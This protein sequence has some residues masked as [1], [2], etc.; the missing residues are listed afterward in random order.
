LCSEVPEPILALSRAIADN[1]LELE[2]GSLAAVDF[3][4]DVL[5]H[6]PDRLLVLHDRTSGW[7]DLGSPA[8]VL[9]T[10]N[11]NC[12]EPEW[13]VRETAYT[14]NKARTLST[15]PD[16]RLGIYFDATEGQK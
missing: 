15:I 7:V 10:L 14:S 12:I 6:V 11:R 5:A 8:R 1:T 4:R 2:Y 16:R 13:A 9:D 3:S